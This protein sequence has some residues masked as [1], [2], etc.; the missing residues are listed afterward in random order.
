MPR[1]ST[2]KPRT[3]PTHIPSLS[4]R[5]HN[6][7]SARSGLTSEGRSM[8]SCRLAELAGWAGVGSPAGDARL[9]YLRAALPARLARPGEDFEL[10]L[11]LAGLPEGVV[12]RVEGGA[13]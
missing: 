8:L 13:A 6:S 5:R 7:V 3:W 10:V 12:V 1:T 11:K 4:R 9:H 2:R